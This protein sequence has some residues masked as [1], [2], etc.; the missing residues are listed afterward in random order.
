M[1]KNAKR[2][3]FYPSV[4]I[5]R[6]W[7]FIKK[8]QPALFHT[9]YWDLI[10]QCIALVIFTVKSHLC[11]CHCLNKSLNRDDFATRSRLDLP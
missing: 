5:A 3:T 2:Q 8:N 11:S 7:I 10:I 4:K 6:Q 1:V 9:Y